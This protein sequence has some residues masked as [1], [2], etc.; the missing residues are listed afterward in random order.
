MG[1]FISIVGKS[2]SGKTLLMEKLVA[3]FKRRGKRIATV[4]HSPK[5]F[6]LDTA[7]KDSWK[8]REAGSDCVMVASEKELACFQRLEHDV[9]PGHVLGL[10]GGGFD[11]ILVE[12]YRGS[13][14]PKIEVHRA[15][16]G[17]ELLCAP[18]ALLAVVGDTAAGAS[19]LPVFGP[20]EVGAIADFIERK[21]LDRVE[22]GVDLRVNGKRVAI[23]PFVQDIIAQSVLGMVST[24]RGVE[25]VKD[26]GVW[27]WRPPGQRDGGKP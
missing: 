21:V 14:L 6:E 2:G 23:K 4:K 20:D 11:V 8:L 5:G 24:L 12:G 18:N 15:E 19:E 3:E 27:V 9:E 22:I 26:V 7:G 25:E 13:R 17:D 10:T 1:P 16:L